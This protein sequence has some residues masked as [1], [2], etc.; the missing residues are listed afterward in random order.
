VSDTAHPHYLHG[1]RQLEALVSPPVDQPR[2]LCWRD[3]DA[4]FVSARDGNVHLV[5]PSFGTRFVLRGVPDTAALTTDGHRLAILGR[6]GTLQLWSLSGP[7]LLWETATGVLGGLQL[8]NWPGGVAVAGDD[9]RGRRV[10]VYDGDGQLR[11]RAR[12]PTRAALGLDA[13]GALVLARSTEAGLVVLP[14]GEILPPGTPTAHQLRFASDHAVVGIA[15]GGVTVWHHPG[16][17]PVSVKLYDVV[18]A[19]LSPNADLVAMGTR[20]GG[21]ALAGAHPGGQRVNPTRVD[22]HEGPVV[23]LAFSPRGRWLASA[24]GRCWVWSY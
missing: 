8:F 23:A 14:F 17:S 24:A 4:L 20:T 9:D 7:V 19:A 16:A 11:K 18:N 10:L 3:S 2:A 6:D 22:G 15:T 5:E 12:V 1:A 13:T 21:V